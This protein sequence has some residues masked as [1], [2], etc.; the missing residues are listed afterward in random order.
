[1]I[2]TRPSE[3]KIDPDFYGTRKDEEREKALYAK[4]SQ[5]ED[6]KEMLKETKEAVLQKHIPKSKAEKD[7]LLMKVRNRIQIE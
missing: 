7:I 4:F 3:I 6:L 1:V 5:N 2:Q